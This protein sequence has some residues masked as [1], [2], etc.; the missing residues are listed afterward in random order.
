MKKTISSVILI[1]TVIWLS[2]CSSDK[3]Q[4]TE[5]PDTVINIPLE[6]P[7]TLLPEDGT[8]R[9]R[10]SE[11]VKRYYIGR[12]IDPNNPDIMYEANTLYR[13]EQ[14]PGWIKTPRPVS[15]VPA[16]VAM[17]VG[18]DKRAQVLIAEFEQDIQV[19]SLAIKK[20]DEQ[21][22][23]N[24]QAVNEFRQ[25]MAK[26]EEIKRNFEKE[27]QTNM[28]FAK[29][30]DEIEH[31]LNQLEYKLIFQQKKDETQSNNTD[32]TNQK[33]PESEQKNN[34]KDLFK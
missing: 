33:Q 32:N 11:N 5:K 19:L 4:P 28:N 8:A 34:I 14:S 12:Y 22:K 13:V 1:A 10:Y 25:A 7:G 16:G 23:E 2:S 26:L 18:A 24:Q 6:V 3:P 31:K 30:C 9:L 29:R 17:K 27:K 21:R 20:I 15:G